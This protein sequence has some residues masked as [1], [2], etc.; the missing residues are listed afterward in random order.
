MTTDNSVSH[1]LALLKEGEKAA[2]QPLWERYFRRLVALARGRLLGMPRGAADE[3]DVAL[4]A[5]AAFC[6]GVAAGRFPDLADRQE[7]WRLLMTLT[8]RKAIHLV[9]DQH[10][11]KRGGALTVE[12]ED[13]DAIV[14]AEPTPAFAAQLAEEFQRQ[15]DRLGDPT[16]RAIALAKLE[17]YTNEEI[18]GKI[19]CAPRTVERKL[20]LIRALW[21][22]EGPA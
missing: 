8:A 4:S 16:L 5:F 1:W 2:A 19:D 13:L 18:A 9:R 12:D 3:E 22:E 15:M 20:R 7:L 21:Q 14:G 6:Q 17:G 11:Q 10:R